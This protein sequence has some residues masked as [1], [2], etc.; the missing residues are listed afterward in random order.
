MSNFHF[1]EPPATAFARGRK[2]H[3][4]TVSD[5]AA[6]LVAN[7]G[8]WARWERPITRAREYQLAYELKKRQPDSTF[9]RMIEENEAGLI[10][11][12]CRCID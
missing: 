10:T 11:F 12:W 8:K 7:P 2:T 4:S 5:Y 3:P 9:E 1:G 6:A